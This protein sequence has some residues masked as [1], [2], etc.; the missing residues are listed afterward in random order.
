MNATGG[1]QCSERNL[2]NWRRISPQPCTC[3]ARLCRV[4][5]PSVALPQVS[6]SLVRKGRC[7]EGHG[8]TDG[9]HN[10]QS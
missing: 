4:N 5:A 3:Y 2:R 1:T 10:F 9:I 8:S 7:Q 6:G